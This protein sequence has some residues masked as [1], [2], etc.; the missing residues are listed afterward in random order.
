MRG[1]ACM[2]KAYKSGRFQGTFTSAEIENI[3]GL[4][5]NR[6]NRYARERKRYAG[7]WRFWICG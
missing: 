2:Y 4:P 6:V 7:T 5:R 3:S 1:K